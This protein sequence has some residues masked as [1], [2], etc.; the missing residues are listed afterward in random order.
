ML[1]RTPVTQ[2][3]LERL[4]AGKKVCCATF[5]P[6]ILLPGEALKAHVLSPCLAVSLR[7]RPR[8]KQQVVAALS[9]QARWC[10]KLALSVATQRPA[11]TRP[12]CLAEPYKEEFHRSQENVCAFE[13]CLAMRLVVD[14]ESDAAT[15]HS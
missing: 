6:A 13:E 4:L 8:P 15:V 14:A 2:R 7:R 11:P 1:W 9:I 5:Q 3:E 10:M 12:A